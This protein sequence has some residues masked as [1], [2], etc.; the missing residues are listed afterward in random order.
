VEEFSVPALA[1]REWA[2]EGVIVEVCGAVDLESQRPSNLTTSLTFDVA[3][4]YW[5]GSAPSKT[6][7]ASGAS[8]AR[9][10]FLR[11]IEAPL[12]RQSRRIGDCFLTAASPPRS[13][14]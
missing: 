12:Q 4:W 2:F 9:K 13:V 7:K 10:P 3:K 11:T 8:T 1:T 5:G 14:T 6:V